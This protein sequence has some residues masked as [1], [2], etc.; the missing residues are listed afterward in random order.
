MIFELNDVCE[1]FELEKARCFPDS[2]ESFFRYKIV[3]GD[4]WS[5]NAEETGDYLYFKNSVKVMN[6]P[7]IVR[8]LPSLADIKWK[9]L[10]S[11]PYFTFGL[12]S[13]Q[14][15]V[16]EERKIGIEGGPCLFGGWEVFMEITMKDGSVKVYD[17]NTGYLVR[18]GAY[19]T[20]EPIVMDAVQIDADRI[21]EIHFR[22][23]KE[24]LT[25]Q[26]IASVLYLFEVAEAL[27]A[28]VVLSIP[29]FS[30]V[31]FLKA[32][33]AYL[34]TDAALSPERSREVRQ[35]QEQCLAE[36]RRIA[37]RI[38]DL[39]L[40]LAKDLA[41][42]YSSVRYEPVHERRDHLCEIFYEKRAPYIER[43]KILRTI[44]SSE[45]HYESLKDYISLSALPYYLFG[46]TDILHICSLDEAD[47]YR[48]CKKAHKGQ[49]CLACILYPE[50]ISADG[51]TT[52]FYAEQKD[53]DYYSDFREYFVES[54]RDGIYR[55]TEWSEQ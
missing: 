50:Y 42:R 33:L 36:F 53:K 31:K 20:D 6:F 35:I 43:N 23:C 44:R 2:M 39:Y 8:T 49:I 3:G 17:F 11:I 34:E 14:E 16:E 28:Q 13:I 29:D 22:D 4:F 51:K 32:V 1:K 40:D 19:V 38:T 18:D 46:I 55:N 54:G 30:Y 12:E 47:S 37:Y 27:D 5:H 15:A 52:V 21:R 25:G 9:D 7:M 24:A 48:K 45:E 26:E 10:E 41:R